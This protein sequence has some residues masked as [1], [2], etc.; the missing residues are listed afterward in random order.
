MDIVVSARSS[1]VVG[2]IPVYVGKKIGIR[3]GTIVVLFSCSD[4]VIGESFMAQLLG[5]YSSVLLITCSV[6][7]FSFLASL[8]P[9]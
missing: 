3:S 8:F 7:R 1:Y 5:H 4:F 6:F 9:A 2:C